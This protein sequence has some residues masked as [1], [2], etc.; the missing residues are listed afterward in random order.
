MSILVNRDTNVII[1]GITGR[2]GQYHTKLMLEF[3]TKIIGG[4]TPGKGG[5]NVLGVPVFNSISELISKTNVINNLATGIFVPGSASVKAVEEAIENKIK[6]IVL[7]TEGIP[8]SDVLYIVSLAKKNNV[9]LIGPNTPGLLS[10]D[11]CKIGILATHYIRRGNIGVVSRSG[12][13]TAEIT[14][15]LFKYD[16]GETSVI[17][18]GGDPVVG[19]GFVPIL[20]QFFADKE[21]DAI[22]MV[23]E[24]GGSLEEEAAEYIKNSKHKKPVVAFVAGQNVPEGRRFGHAGAIIQNGTGSAESKI[25]A[26]KSAGVHIARV[27]WEIGSILSELNI[28][29]KIYE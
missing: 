14:Q 28:P 13:L 7:I 29:K 27:P 26:L 10:T 4:V 5:Q 8:L 16:Y 22:V 9:T 24:V 1:Q 2:E 11:G 23:G 15:N 3:G 18:I 19:T 6:L 25:T 12:T 17:G 20:E 21:T